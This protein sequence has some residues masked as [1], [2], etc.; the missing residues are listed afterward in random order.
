MVEYALDIV[1]VC[2]VAA[3]SSYICSLISE[4][5]NCLF[6]FWFLIAGPREEDNVLRTQ[7]DHPLRD[8]SPQTAQTPTEEICR[9]RL[10]L[11]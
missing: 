8:T 4:R 5:P 7:P 9:F 6:R 11:D 10:E 1:S 3:V 2:N